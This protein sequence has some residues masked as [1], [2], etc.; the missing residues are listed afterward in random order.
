MMNADRGGNPKL[1]MLPFLITAMCRVCRTT[2][3][4][5]P[6]MTTTRRC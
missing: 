6:A 1:T 3:S 2:R 4:S 5:T